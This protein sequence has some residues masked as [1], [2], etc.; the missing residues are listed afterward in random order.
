MSKPTSLGGKHRHW[1]DNDCVLARIAVLGDEVAGVAGEY[2]VFDA[3]LGTATQS[4]HFR[5]ATKMVSCVVTA[6]SARLYGTFDGGLEIFPARVAQRLHEVADKPEFDAFVRYGAI[7]DEEKSSAD[8]ERIQKLR[9][10]MSALRRRQEG[11]RSENT[12]EVQ[13]VFDEYSQAGR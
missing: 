3:A 4:D 11:L 12:A 5:D 13:A 8:P 9:D 2:E 7:D 1:H 10:E 6:C